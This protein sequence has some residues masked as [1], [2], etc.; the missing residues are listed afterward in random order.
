MKQQLNAQDS[1]APQAT[2]SPEQLLQDVIGQTP[3]RPARADGIAIGTFDG[4]A[5]DGCALVTIAAFGLSRIPARCMATLDAAENGQS[6]ALGFEGGD[7]MRPIVIGL[8]LDAPSRPAPVPTEVVLDG[9]HV[10][11][12]AQ[13][14]IELRCGDAALILSADGRIELRGTYITSQASATQRILGGSVNIN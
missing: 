12:T 9:E 11:L 3:Q 13:E 2:G 8:M 5:D 6:L 1:L 4:M 14:Q 7:P 10:V